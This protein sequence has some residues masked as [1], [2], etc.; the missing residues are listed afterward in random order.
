MTQDELVQ[1]IKDD[2][3]ASCSLDLDVLNDAELVRII[4]AEKRMAF[5]EWPD[6]VE[7][8]LQIFPVQ[9]FQ[10]PEFKKTRTIQLPNCVYGVDKFQEIKDGSRLFGINDP[11]LNIDQVMGSDLWLSPFSS[12]VIASRTVAWSWYDL[13]KSF[14]LTEIQHRFNIATHRLQVIGRDPK[15]AV[16]LQ[17]YVAIDDESLYDYYDFQRF[18][19]AR[20]KTQL[21][22]VLKT[23]TYNVVGGVQITDMYKEEGESE[24]KEIKERQAN[25]S[26]PNWFVAVQ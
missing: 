1:F 18:C 15:C 16:L 7:L 4:N 6:C 25:L 3:T 20:A 17:A 22:R 13:A 26:Q 12:D 14:T 5:M 10:T 19:I 24:M 2:L 23:F 11:N 21:H 8:R 9:C